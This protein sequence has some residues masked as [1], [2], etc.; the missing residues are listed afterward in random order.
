MGERIFL[1][2]GARSGKS[3]LGESLALRWGGSDVTYI[4]TAEAGDAEMARRIDLHRASR[5]REWRTWEGEPQALPAFV[6]GLEGVVL[7]DC[8]TVWLS[9][10]FLADPAVES[11]D[12]T[13]WHEG[14]RKILA[15]VEALFDAAGKAERFIVVS[16]EVGMDL[17]PPNRMGRRFR[18]LQGRANQIG[19]ARAETALLVVAGLPLVL[20]GGLDD[21][22]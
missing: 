10:L 15:S 2:G 14:E 4:A 16:N 18:D 7:M 21:G 20:K 17:V 9:R 3:R 1:L 12:E 13:L 6:E 8:L 5:P 19:A 22:R 11:D